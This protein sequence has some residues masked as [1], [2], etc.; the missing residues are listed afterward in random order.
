[1]PEISATSGKRVVTTADMWKPPVTVSLSDVQLD[2]WEP[3]VVQL[4]NNELSEKANPALVPWLNRVNAVAAWYEAAKHINAYGETYCVRDTSNRMPKSFYEYVDQEI[5]AQNARRRGG[6]PPNGPTSRREYMLQLFGAVLRQPYN[7]NLLDSVACL[8][9]SIVA[10]EAG[11]SS[12]TRRN[13]ELPTA[14]N[15]TKIGAGADS[16]VGPGT[17]RFRR[18]ELEFPPGVPPPFILKAQVMSDERDTSAFN[19][20]LVGLYALNAL[21]HFIPNFM[22]VYGSFRTFGPMVRYSDGTTRIGSEPQSRGFPRRAKVRDVKIFSDGHT[23]SRYN[24]VETISGAISAQEWVF[25]MA[26]R[27]DG[28]RRIA[29][30]AYQICL[31]LVMARQMHGFS[32][33]D[34]HSN[35]VLISELGEPRTLMYTV[36]DVNHY[37][38]ETDVLVHIIDFGRSHIDIPLR[39]ASFAV[40]P[41]GS[42]PP[43]VTTARNGRHTFH[44][45]NISLRAGQAPVAANSLYDLARIFSCFFV[46]VYEAQAP[47]REAMEL[48][49]RLMRPF[50]SPGRMFTH[51]EMVVWMLTHYSITPAAIDVDPYEY[52]ITIF[53]DMPEYLRPRTWIQTTPIGGKIVVPVEAP[54]LFMCGPSMCSSDPFLAPRSTSSFTFSREPP[55]I[56][57]DKNVNV[58]KVLED[59]EKLERMRRKV[60]DPSLPRAEMEVLDERITHKF[61]DMLFAEDVEGNLTPPGIPSLVSR[62]TDFA[63]RHRARYA[64]RKM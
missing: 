27:P 51:E 13:G 10:E 45:G 6:Y 47:T 55:T 14:R 16:V 23:W 9:Q 40:Q 44:T 24:M 48:V 30:V 38:L 17:T 1:M 7:A 46:H 59:L 2:T 39:D 26:S 36:N 8:L 53:D 29:A 31:A 34:L 15:L 35:N 22:Y 60:S 56:V 3:V 5:E 12:D 19:E 32:H 63:R 20:L 42:L 33:N 52:F 49:S 11:Y 57:P 4:N 37:F 21:R 43:F 50:F 25:A 41:D 64:E 58:A 18:E 28:A 62:L 54:R 61:W